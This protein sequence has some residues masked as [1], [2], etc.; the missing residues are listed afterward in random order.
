MDALRFPLSPLLS[1]ED[2]MDRLMS[3]AEQRALDTRCRLP[4]SPASRTAVVKLRAMLPASQ[5]QCIAS[6]AQSDL[7]NLVRCALTAGISADVRWGE[8][9]EPVLCIAAQEGSERALKALLDGGANVNL[10]DKSGNTAAHPAA[11][12][13]HAPCLRL[14]LDAGANLEAKNAD[15]YTP[16]HH[17]AR[18]GHAECCSL[19]LSKGCNANARSP[20]G[21]VSACLQTACS[22]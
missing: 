3:D 20:L 15:G 17:A 8:Y 11:G 10:A 14:L 2:A 12:L 21:Q 18:E 22:Y 1:H 13:G 16:L 19:L 4:A 5:A 9:D 6:Y 7:P